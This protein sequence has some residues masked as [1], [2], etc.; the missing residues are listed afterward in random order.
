MA[1]KR[2][3]TFNQALQEEFPFI[4]KGKSDSDVRCSKC[5]ATF[6]IANS[7]RSAINQHLQTSKH[8]DADRQAS[9][10]KSLNE[11]FVNKRDNNTQNALALKEASWCYHSVQHNYSFRSSDCSSKL[12]KKCFEEKYSCA[13]T[14][15]ESIICNV[16]APYSFEAIKS[17]LSETNYITIYSDCS[18]HG[19]TKLCTILVRY[20]LP[21]FGVRVKVLN[22]KQLPGENSDILTNCINES[23]EKFGATKKLV[24]LCADN[25]NVNFGGSQR[26]GENNVLY[27]MQQSSKKKLIGVN[28]AAH[29]FN[30]CISTAVDCLP[31]DIEVVLVKIYSHFYIYTIRVEILKQFCDEAEVQY[32]KLLGYSKTRWLTLLPAL[33]RVLQLFE[34]LKAYFLNRDKCPTIL[35]TFF[36]GELS[37]EWLFFVHNQASM[38]HQYILKAEG[39]DISMCETSLLV[40]EL[41]TKLNSR[42]NEKFVPIVIKKTLSKVQDMQSTQFI[43]EACT[44]YQTCIEYLSNWDMCFNEA[45]VFEWITLREVPVWSKVEASYIFI[46]EQCSVEISD[47]ELFDEITLVKNYITNEKIDEWRQNSKSCHLRWVEIFNHFKANHIAFNNT[48][49]LIEFA[50]CLPGTN[51][52]VERIFSL[53]NNMWTSDKTQLSVST[54]Q[55]SIAVKFNFEMNCLEFHDFL[56]REPALLRKIHTSGKYEQ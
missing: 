56:K 6:N 7:G 32:K 33:D 4:K 35:K 11:F 1:P 18:N 2:K 12:I 49:K 31:I 40:K 13:R 54:L 22:I 25:T 20:F 55:A 21:N 43:S 27:K 28:C 15:T 5:L 26:R 52:P 8:K 39:Q 14:K 36:N 29:I 24:A 23:L 9:T 19:N 44:F 50:L 3:C 48:C 53:V 51:A 37:E 41:K 30:N 10:S 17:D 38:F 46:S 34:P 45:E 16:F 42:K 47:G